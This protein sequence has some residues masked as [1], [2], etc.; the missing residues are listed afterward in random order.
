MTADSRRCFCQDN[1][2][3]FLERAFDR[4]G[5]DDAQRQ[6]LLQSFRETSVQI[7]LE[8]TTP[9]GERKL[10]T[11]HGYRVQHNHARGPFKGGVRFH[12]EVSQTEVRALAQLMTWKTALADL[13]FGGGKGGIAVDPSLL[14]LRELETL[15]K[16]FTQKMGPVIGINDDIMAPDVNT[17]PQVMAWM[18][19]EYS[20]T[21]GFSPA[22]VTGKPLELGGLP[23]RLEATGYGV[24]FIAARAAADLGSSIEGARVAVQGF[25]NVGSHAAV[26]LHELGAKV[27]ALS[28][29]TGGVLCADGIDVD[30]ALRHARETGSLQGCPGTEAI[31]NEELLELSCEILVPAALEATINCDNEPRIQARIIVEAANMPVTHSADQALAERGVFVVPDIL[32][33]CGGVVASYFEWVQNVQ[34]FPWQRSVVFDRLEQRL[35]ATYDLVAERARAEKEVFRTAS[36]DLAVSRVLRAVEL[37]GF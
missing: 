21:H 25:G 26:R 18:F 9:A 27:I 36:Y 6:L 3:H 12:P 37:R 19:E 8:I 22:I 31:T 5:L 14:G 20:K 23:G 28:D 2:R 35:A 29:V 4:L 1:Q 15:T 7:P 34:Q 33:N 17:N 10:H 11:F 30:R 16:R 24:A 32:A 13:P